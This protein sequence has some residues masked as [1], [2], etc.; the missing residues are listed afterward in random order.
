MAERFQLGDN[1]LTKLF[2]EIHYQRARELREFNSD[3]IINIHNLIYIISIRIQ[4]M[5]SACV[6]FWTD[7][8]VKHFLIHDG[9]P[10]LSDDMLFFVRKKPKRGT[11][12]IP[13]YETEIE[14]Y[15][16]ESRKL[17]IGDPDVDW[18]ETVYLNLILQ[19]FEYTLTCAICTRTSPKDLQVLRRHSQRVYASP[20]KRSMD[21]K[22]DNE[23]ITYPNLFFTVDNFDDVFGDIIVRDGEMVCVELL[24]SDKHGSIQSVVFLGS[25]RYE[26]LKRVYDARTSASTKFAQKMS[27]GWF[28]SGQRLEFVR[29]KGPMGKGHA[30]MAVAK[31]KGSGVE[32]PTSEPGFNI[33]DYDDS[34]YDEPEDFQYR[35]RRMSDPSS[36]LNNYVREFRNRREVKK[37]Q[38]ENEG[39]DYYSNGVNE[40][41]AGDLRDE[42]L[43]KVHESCLKKHKCAPISQTKVDA[44]QNE[45]PKSELDDTTYNKLWTM[46]GFNQAF[47]FWKESRRAGSVA[48]HAYLTYVTLPWHHIIADL[49]ESKT[50][51]VLTF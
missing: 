37:S 4:L 17:P 21:R 29:M 6:T 16:R 19:E 11:R 47:H 13:Q 34:D 20:S 43:S 9:D 38:S 50:E 3:G 28:G 12:Y 42:T 2:S 5:P 27:M 44:A 18:E 40:I 23:K 1:R 36:N 32:T 51:P 15:R 24:A 25:I 22:G 8:F 7:L 30:E 10:Y 48:L 14:V 49:L 46:K 26:A 31:Q 33:T 41:E 35:K 39:V 45:S